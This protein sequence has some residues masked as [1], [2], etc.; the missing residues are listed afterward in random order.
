MAEAQMHHGYHAGSGALG[1]P[2]MQP[3]R[4]A[5]VAHGM[6]PISFIHPP[7]AVAH[8]LTKQQ[9]LRGLR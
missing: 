9:E 5:R 2:Q 4:V 6:S 7:I 3:A 8:L 1:R